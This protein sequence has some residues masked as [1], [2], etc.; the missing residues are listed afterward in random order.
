MCPSSANMDL[1]D[2]GQLRP[3]KNAQPNRYHAWYRSGRIFFLG[4]Y[5]AVL[6]T[7]K[8]I[9]KK[10]LNARVVG[11]FYV[12][13]LQMPTK[14]IGRVWLWLVLII[15]TATT[16][17]FDTLLLWIHSKKNVFVFFSFYLPFS[18]L[19]R[20]AVYM[21]I[22]RPSE[23]KD[24][25]SNK[26]CM[27]PYS[28]RKEFGILHLTCTHKEV[29]TLFVWTIMFQHWNCCLI[30][31]ANEDK[32]MYQR[33]IWILFI[34]WGFAS[35]ATIQAYPSKKI[36]THT[37]LFITFERPGIYIIKS[38]T[39]HPVVAC[40]RL[41]LFFSSRYRRLCVRF[42]TRLCSVCLRLRY[43]WRIVFCQ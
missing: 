23:A 28:T 33:L 10:L 35:I 2:S 36:K 26:Y 7:Q 16:W 25:N 32:S 27:I 29:S 4:R 12:Y 40:C 34:I 6:K 9:G 22:H 24:W 42:V 14:R 20:G 5:H 30:V 11:F 43:Y 39:H 19:I 21:D 38:V 15:P 37:M 41:L 8:R 3:R 13:W 17:I 1:R 18:L 31:F